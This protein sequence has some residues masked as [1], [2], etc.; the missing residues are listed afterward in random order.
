M[1][2]RTLGMGLTAI[3][4]G[5]V[6][7]YHNV[8]PAKAPTR[9]EVDGKGVYLKSCKECHGV[10]GS[11]PKASLRKYEKIPNFADPE[12]YKTR[13]QAEL[14]KA[15]DKGKGRDM[16]GFADKLSKEEINA[17]VAYVRTLEK[18]G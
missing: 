15:V 11:P 2:G 12:F 13:T 10:L 1:K 9:Q 5:A 7:M 17:V 3:G 14:L 18:K 16:K 8:A 4:V 6:I